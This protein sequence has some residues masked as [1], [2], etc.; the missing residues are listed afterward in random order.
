MKFINVAK[1]A[2]FVLQKVLPDISKCYF[3]QGATFV[4]V[5]SECF[6]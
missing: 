5:G 2:K 1:F 6:L 3:T 4:K